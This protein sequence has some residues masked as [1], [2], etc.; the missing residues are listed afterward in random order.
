MANLVIA[1]DPGHGGKNSGLSYNGLLEKHMNRVTAQAMKEELEQFENV[2]VI[3]TNPDEET[4]L[5]LKDR[6]NTAKEAGADVLISL[7]YNMSEE[8]TM[9]GSEVWVPCAGQ[10]HADMHALGDIFLEQFDEIGLTIRGVK[11]RLNDRGTDYYGIIRE[12]AARDLRA[13]LVEHCY[14]DHIQDENYVTAEEN[15]KA[16]GKMDAEAVAKYYRLKSAD[17]TRDYTEY[18][19]NGYMVPDEAVKPDK[20]GPEAVSVKWIE[21]I[22][23]EENKESAE[24]ENEAEENGALEKSGADT[25][26]S[27]A[28]E[29]ALDDNVV[30]HIATEEELA[31]LTADG[32]VRNDNIQVYHIQGNEPDT[33]IVYYEYSLD[34]GETWSGLL[35]FA[36]NDTQMDIQIRGV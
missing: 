6:A 30:T 15:W 5:S 34:G 23:A 7:H 35:P 26:E 22:A 3:I 21:T 19:K 27:A 16:F 24:Q 33:S 32:R 36:K 25:E 9:F 29:T 12:S 8:H 28:E 13:I 11:T 20:T 14:A 10:R 31:N 18:V 4:D 2:E 17:G 1:I